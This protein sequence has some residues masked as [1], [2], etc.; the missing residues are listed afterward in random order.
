MLDFDLFRCFCDW[1]PPEC[2]RT[3]WPWGLPAGLKIEEK[4]RGLSQVITA[5]YESISNS[6]LKAFLTFVRKIAFYQALS[7]AI[8]L[9]VN[10]RKQWQWFWIFNSSLLR[11]LIC[12]PHSVLSHFQLF[13]SL[14]EKYR[15][16]YYDTKS[17]TA[18]VP[19]TTMSR[20][21]WC[22]L[23]SNPIAVG[24][25]TYILQSCDPDK[26]HW[27]KKQ[28]AHTSFMESTL[29]E[30][31]HCSCSMIS[32]RLIAGGLGTLGMNKNIYHVTRVEE[33]RV[34]KKPMTRCWASSSENTWWRLSS[35]FSTLILWYN[36]S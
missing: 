22:D 24:P 1:R 30:S 12:F 23:T 21:L 34:N 26:M 20:Q 36:R 17:K 15:W 28:K 29:D 11:S 32:L 25:W 6:Y 3:A 2:H 31:W 10:K 33:D 18:L 16:F 27:E 4:Q 5:K 35:I 14:F 9:S 13:S 8:I 7:E 19:K